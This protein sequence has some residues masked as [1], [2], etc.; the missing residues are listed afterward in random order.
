MKWPRK[1]AAMAAL[2]ALAGPALAEPGET[3]APLA[4]IDGKAI[5]VVDGDS[6]G[7][8]GVE[9]RL[10]GFDAPETAR[11]VCEAERRLG[12]IA[13]S[14]LE[15][16][17][18]DAV[19]A[20]Q[21][22]D[23]AASGER[24]RYRRPLAH[25][26]IDG[27]DVGQMLIQELLARPTSAGASAAGARGTTATISSPAC[28]RSGC[29]RPNHQGFLDSCHHPYL[30]IHCR[31]VRTIARTMLTTTG[32]TSASP[33]AERQRASSALTARSDRPCPRS[34]SARP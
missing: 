12:L 6:L 17:I 27:A 32:M 15:T 30:T 14:R 18:R 22:V 25:L 28:L 7:V 20:G 29:G 23:L 10:I 16:M 19:A 13:K 9:W 11:A 33:S 4:V 21:P 1:A 24:D 5:T 3:P 2:L 26:R 8:D 31:S 34:R